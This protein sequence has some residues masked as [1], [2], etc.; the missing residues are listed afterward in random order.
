MVV[1]SWLDE[2][3]D[4]MIDVAGVDDDDVLVIDCTVFGDDSLD[5]TEATCCCC[6]VIC[7]AYCCS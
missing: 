5:S 7:W 4:S 2:Y 6:S 3:G 1:L